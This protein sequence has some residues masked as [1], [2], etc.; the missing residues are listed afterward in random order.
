MPAGRLTTNSSGM[1]PVTQ[2]TT[3][4]I[5]AAVGRPRLGGADDDCCPEPY[6]GGGGGGGG[7]P[8]G[9]FPMVSTTVGTGGA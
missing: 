9:P 8:L 4:K 2:E 7:Y 5:Q 6:G 1:S 3:P